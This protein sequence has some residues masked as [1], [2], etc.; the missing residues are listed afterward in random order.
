MFPKEDNHIDNP[1]DLKPFTSGGVTYDAIYHGLYLI[2]Q[3]RYL[4]PKEFKLLDKV[5]PQFSFYKIFTTPKMKKLAETGYLEEVDNGIYCVP[6][7]V[8][9]LLRKRGFI[10]K[11]LPSKPEGKGGV[12][13]MNNIR[14]FIKYM[15]KPDYLT[16]LFPT[17]NYIE[18][19]ALLVRKYNT[20]TTE[21]NKPPRVC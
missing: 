16:L 6:D 18:P 21:G 17:F 3:L 10:T 5:Y 19:D 14:E 8:I 4:S 2:R 11:Y 9:D 13:V 1:I 12:N 7:R 20:E 15:E